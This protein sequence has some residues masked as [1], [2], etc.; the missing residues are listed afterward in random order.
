MKNE[1]SDKT[2]LVF[3][4]TG[5]FMMCSVLDIL[6]KTYFKVRKYYRVYTE[7]KRLLEQI[8]FK[9]EWNRRVPL[10]LRMKR[11]GRSKKRYNIE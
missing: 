2:T 9:R 8:K 3:L 11:K 5:F 4:V 1:N 7:M 6:C 10:V